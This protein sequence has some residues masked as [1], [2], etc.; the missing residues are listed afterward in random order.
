[1]WS[2]SMRMV[3]S[4]LSLLYCRPWPRLSLTINRSHWCYQASHHLHHE[5]RDGLWECKPTDTPSHTNRVATMQ[6]A[7]YPKSAVINWGG[8]HW[9]RQ[10][11]PSSWHT[12]VHQ[13][14][15]KPRYVQR[16]RPRGDRKSN[17]RRPCSRTS[18]Q[19]Y[20]FKQLEQEPETLP[21]AL[22]LLVD[23]PRHPPKR[24]Q[25]RCANISEERHPSICPQT[26]PWYR[27]NQESSSWK[28]LVARHL[29]RHRQVHIITLARSSLRQRSR[30]HHS[31][32]PK[33]PNNHGKPLA[34]TSKVLSQ[35][36]K[37]FLYCSTTTPDIVHT[38]TRSST[39]I[40]IIKK[41]KKT[42]LLFG[43][44][45]R[46]ISDNG[47][48]FISIEFKQFL[49]QHNIEHHPVTPYW[50]KANGE[51]KRFNA[52]IG[53]ILQH[54]AKAEQKDWRKEL[55]ERTRRFF[56]HLQINASLWY[57]SR[58]ADLLFKHKMKNDIPSINVEVSCN[59]SAQSKDQDY[60]QKVKSRADNKHPTY[61]H[62]Y[63]KGDK[64][65][66]KNLRIRAI[67]R[68]WSVSIQ[69]Q[70]TKQQTLYHSS[71]HTRQTVHPDSQQNWHC[72]K[73]WT[74]VCQLTRSNTNVHVT[75]RSLARSA[76]RLWNRL[77][78]QEWNIVYRHYSL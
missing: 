11:C 66:A 57:P 67:H 51:V 20:S 43:Y 27:Q 28:S 37:T 19:K 64:I 4:T 14:D 25:H 21:P 9:V 44:P 22:S 8:P 55:E 53:K 63:A 35:P 10:L 12:R 78:F 76:N 74:T 58:P 36:V 59:Q 32:C 29:L 49:K 18:S 45:Q 77:W 65:L 61:K 75:T 31:K 13:N 39:S 33:C 24:P 47:K 38:W 46:I 3:T 71:Q 7:P 2:P 23:P 62:N 56:P 42:F 60:K 30:P 52:S 72:N 1:M 40:N 73:H 16:H 70:T 6:Q 34:L 69:C 50:P 68:C 41:L 54:Y 26:A 15:C 5:S 17:Q 48:Q